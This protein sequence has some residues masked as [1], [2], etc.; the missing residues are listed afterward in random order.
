M[1]AVTSNHRAFTSLLVLVAFLPGGALAEGLPDPLPLAWC[2]ERAQ[3]AN[4]QIAVDLAARDAA[5]ERVVPAGALDDPRLAYDASNVPSD[6]LDFDSTPLSGHQFGLRQKLPFPG[7]LS[8]RKAAARAGADAASLL[9]EDRRLTTSSGVES[10]WAELGFAQRAL[11]ITNRNVELLRQLTTIAEAKYRVGTG[12]QQDVLRAQVELTALLQEKLR[13]EAGLETADA[14]LAALL[15]LPPETSFPQ[16]E[17]LQER[18]PAPDLGQVLENVTKKNAQ[19]RALTARIDEAEKRVRVSKLEGYPDFD[20]GVGYRVRERVVGDAVNGDDF[21]SAG[22]TIRLPINRAKWRSR[23]AERNALLRRAKAERRVALTSLSS[24]IRRA[25]ADLIR[26]QSEEELLRTGLVPQAEQSLES[27]RSAY[28]VGR[29]DFL[30]LLN[31][32]VRLLQAELQL[33]RAQADRRRAYSRLESA[34]GE[35]LR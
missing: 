19:L 25:H 17:S 28:Q 3:A 8:N 35:P 31:S 14:R 23:V 13:H 4:P 12:L 11:E 30:S 20:L 24:E 7:L 5:E 29:I 10:A 22:V 18:T 1:G 32:Q 21:L 27:S 26:S 16:T 9:V 6:D 2:I 15:D 33:V 34:S